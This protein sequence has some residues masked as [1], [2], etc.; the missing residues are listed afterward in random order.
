M[1]ILIE[2]IVVVVAIIT[3][4]NNLFYYF[5]AMFKNNRRSFSFLLFLFLI[6]L[7]FLLFFFDKKVSWFGGYVQWPLTFW[8]RVSSSFIDR[9]FETF[10][11]IGELAKL[12][13]QL[14]SAQ[15]KIQFLE[16]QQ[17]G[18]EVLKKEVKLLREQLGFYLQTEW[19]SIPAHIIAKD[20]IGSTGMLTIDKGENEGVLKDFPVIAYQDGKYALVGKVHQSFSSSSRV[21][22]II[23]SNNNV[24]VRLLESRYE[25][26]LR[27]QGAFKSYL[28]LDYL[29]KELLKYIKSKEIVITSGL[30]DLYPPDIFIGEVVKV[31]EDKYLPYLSAEVLPYIEMNRLEYVF[32]LKRLPVSSVDKT[33]S[34]WKKEGKR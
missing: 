5:S 1:S 2:T 11:A 8:Q 24:S 4:I 22:P 34:I 33:P 29:P 9:T 16:R 14:D 18:S 7:C 6:S 19:Q 17:V 15:K 25:G 31:G 20:P 21:I 30:S 12:K 32:I 3:P 27:G 26:I 10:N 23:N 13:E 28:I